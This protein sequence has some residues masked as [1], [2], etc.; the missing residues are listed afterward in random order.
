MPELL[1]P[2]VYTLEVSS[3]V[4][5][6]EGVS[7]STAAFIG[8]ADKGP[9]PRTVLPTGRAAQPVMVTSLTDYTSQCRRIRRDS[10]LT[11]SVRSIY[12]NGGRRLYTVRV[13]PAGVALPRVPVSSPP[14]SPP[15]STLQ[16]VAANEG[17]GGNNIWMSKGDSSD[18]NT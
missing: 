18:G 10:F 4:R 13:A 11:Y 1:H 14:L 9:I 17:E 3:G 8:V 15:A 2:G 6:I 7:T 16:I 12:G 5:P